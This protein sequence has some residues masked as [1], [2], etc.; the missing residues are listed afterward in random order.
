MSFTAIRPRERDAL[1]Q[2]LRAGV[3]PRAGQRHVQVGREPEVTAMVSDID[4]IASGG[5]AVRFV[6]GDFGAGK[7]F[8]LHLVRSIAMEKKLV[9][10]HADLNPDRRL[11]SSSGQA[12]SLYAEL[13]RNLATRAKPDGGALTSVVERFVSTALAEAQHSGI[14]PGHVI[15]QRLAHLSEMTGGY[16]FAEVVGAYWRGHDSGDEQLKSAAVRWLRAEYSTKT[17][18]RS[19]LGVRTIID[20]STFHD[21]LKLMSRFVR[22]AGYDGLLVCLDEM[23]NLYKLASTQAR[24]A[25]Y[26][27]IL[28]ILNDTLQGSA[29]HLGFVFGGT[30][31]FLADTRRG[32]YSYAALQS[33]LTENTFATGGLVDYSGPVLRL[34]ALTQE[35]LY[36]LL[37]KLRHVHAGGDPTRYLLG[38]E[39]LPAFMHH[40]SGRIGEAYFRTPRTT[41]KAFC[42]LLAVLEQNPGVDWRQILPSVELALEANPDLA[43]LEEDH[44]AATPAWVTQGGRAGDDDLASF[45]L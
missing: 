8:F 35:D 45:R 16:D 44:S 29:A 3:V 27:Q 32:L 5:S 37:A 24:N 19:A 11:H 22:L 30:P 18:A 42:D 41:I 13:M 36:V 17:E 38:D 20:D 43:P 31:E 15:R 34:A 26:E 7:T 10:V 28:R 39:A 4:R 21:H 40:C 14:D 1:L 33:R 9:T 6:I 12:R 25:N 2:S 23:V